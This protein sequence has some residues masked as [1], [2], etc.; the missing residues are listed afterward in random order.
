MWVNCDLHN[1]LVCTN[2]NPAIRRNFGP[3][4]LEVRKNFWK[5]LCTTM[6]RKYHY[7]VTA[8]KLF[9]IWS[10]RSNY[11][12]RSHWCLHWRISS[13]TA[14]DIHVDKL[15]ISTVIFSLSRYGIRPRKQSS[16]LFIPDSP[17]SET[18]RSEL[19]PTVHHWVLPAIFVLTMPR[20]YD[21]RTRIS[22]RQVH[23]SSC[24]L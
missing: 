11:Q 18:W 17:R 4:L 23:R 20:R 19:P 13:Y 12:N 10:R 24:Q 8:Q 9:A 22:A 1:A 5:L 21:P 3:A 16:V 15:F 7:C 14:H 6:S 2:Y